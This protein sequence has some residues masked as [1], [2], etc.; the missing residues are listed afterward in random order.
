MVPGGKEYLEHG[1]EVSAGTISGENGRLVFGKT[2]KNGSFHHAERERVPTAPANPSSKRQIY[3]RRK[4][5]GGAE[6]GER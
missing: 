6:K 5:Q 4:R 1:R 3:E 2:G